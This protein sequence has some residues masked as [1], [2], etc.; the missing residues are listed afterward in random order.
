[1]RNNMR[2][3]FRGGFRTIATSKMEQF[4][5]IGNGFQPLN[6]I[7]KHSILDVVAVLDPPLWL[8]SGETWPVLLKE[9]NYFWLYWK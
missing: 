5:I 4:V 8:K 6:I 7:A 3:W 2:D 9:R 1:M